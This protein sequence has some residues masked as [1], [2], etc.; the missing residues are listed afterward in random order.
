[1]SIFLLVLQFLG[2]LI[3]FL[4]FFWRRLR[5]DFD[6]HVIFRSGFMMAIGF[7]IGQILF[8][9]LIPR[10]FPASNI[11][12]YTGLWF[13]GALLGL[14]LGF[15]FSQK[16]FALPLYESLEA[17]IVGFLFA[18]PIITKEWVYSLLAIGTYYFL[19]SRYKSFSWYKSGK[20]GFAGLATMGVFFT[21]RSVLAFVGSTM[22]VFT[23]IGKVEVVLCAALAFLSFFAV[24]NLSS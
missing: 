22:L 24:Y 2:S 6:A 13:W 12:S 21:V 20:V 15:V 19:K 1:M 16:V 4:F 7:G 9:A 23:G 18:S 17:A 5:E 3:L 10:L 11:F 8:A 14:S